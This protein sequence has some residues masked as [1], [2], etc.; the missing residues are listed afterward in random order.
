MWIGSIRMR[1]A[2]SPNGS[3]IYADTQSLSLSLSFSSS[4]EN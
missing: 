3:T 4:N 2:R 1:D